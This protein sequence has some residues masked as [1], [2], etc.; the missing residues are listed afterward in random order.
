MNIVA[1]VGFKGQLWDFW[2]KLSCH[3]SYGRNRLVCDCLKFNAFVF[4]LSSIVLDWLIFHH[5]QPRS[6]WFPDFLLLSVVFGRIIGG[7]IRKCQ[8][9]K[10]NLCAYVCMCM[11]GCVVKSFLSEI[12]IYHLALVRWRLNHLLGHMLLNPDSSPQK[13]IKTFIRN[14][15]HWVMLTLA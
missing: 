2:S 14:E 6:K 1:T 7:C 11:C 5:F 10:K 4:V 8:E 12:C 13:F 15:N 9:E 3:K